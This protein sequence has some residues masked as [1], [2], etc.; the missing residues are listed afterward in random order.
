MVNFR[1]AT[2]LPILNA[3]NLFI[4]L[5]PYLVISVALFVFLLMLLGSMTEEE[6][7][8]Y[9]LTESDTIQ[10]KNYSSCND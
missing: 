8:E 10:L 3:T 9:E 4:A 2:F 1:S 7:D 5:I 6:E